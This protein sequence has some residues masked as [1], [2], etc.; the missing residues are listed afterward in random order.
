MLVVA[1]AATV[2][3]SAHADDAFDMKASLNYRLAYIQTGDPEVDAM[4]KA[5]LLGLTHALKDR[6]AV[7]PSDPIGVDV[8]NDELAFFPLLYWPLTQRQ[9]QLSAN[10]L[11]KVDAFM[12]NGG[13][14]VFDTRDQSTSLP[15]ATQAIER[16]SVT[17]RRLMAGLDIPPLQPL[18]Q[19]HVLSRTFYLLREYPGRWAGGKVWVEGRQSTDDGG[20]STTASDEVSPIIVGGADW[21]AAWAEDSEGRPIAAVAPG[22][23]RQR[24]LAMRFG[25]NLVMYTLTGNYK[26]DLVHVPHILERLGQ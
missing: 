4:S 26:A 23:D 1:I 24:E 3:A 21:A 20:A 6:T 25:V 19:D 8:E 22:G 7:E 10:A 11:S 14:I 9:P 18:N 12:R 13:T 16:G 15:I 5:G 17:L 2:I